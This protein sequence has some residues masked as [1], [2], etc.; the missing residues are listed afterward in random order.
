MKCTG[1]SSKGS[2][3]NSLHP[4]GGSQLSVVQVTRDSMPSSVLSG[5]YTHVLHRYTC[6]QNTYIPTIKIKLKILIF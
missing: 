1:C 2:G 3:F 4:H 5:H 6:K